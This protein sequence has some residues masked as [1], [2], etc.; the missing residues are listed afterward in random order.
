MILT[1]RLCEEQGPVILERGAAEL[2]YLRRTVTTGWW[3]PRVSGLEG[4][5]VDRVKAHEWLED[6]EAVWS[7]VRT[8]CGASSIA[9]FDERNA[10]RTEV[11][12]LRRLLEDTARWLRDAGHPVKA[13]LIRR[14]LISGHDDG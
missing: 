1:K 2:E 11:D 3:E 12:R 5:Y 8:W 4:R 6:A 10:L 9:A 14:E 13:G 7:V